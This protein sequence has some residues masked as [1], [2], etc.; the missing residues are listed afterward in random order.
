MGLNTQRLQ[1]LDNNHHSRSIKTINY[2]YSFNVMHNNLSLGVADRK[3]LVLDEP[4]VI[5]SIY[6]SNT[7]HWYSSIALV[8]TGLQ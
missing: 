8:A 5:S 4:V 7:D 6:K 1:L 3:L 2:C